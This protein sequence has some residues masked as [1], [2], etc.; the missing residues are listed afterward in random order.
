MTNKSEY[1]GSFEPQIV[2]LEDIS[3][4]N[5]VPEE[6]KTFLGKEEI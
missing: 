6:I 2:K 3:N 1:K 5:L 4:L